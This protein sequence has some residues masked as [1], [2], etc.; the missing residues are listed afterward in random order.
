MQKKSTQ[1]SVVGGWRRSGDPMERSCDVKGI[2]GKI[3]H[4]PL[5]MRRSC[6]H[7]VAN[8]YP[9][10][11][12]HYW[13]GLENIILRCCDSHYGLIPVSFN[14]LF[15]PQPK[16]RVVG[17]GGAAQFQIIPHTKLINFLKGPQMWKGMKIASC[18]CL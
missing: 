7:P 16:K 18:S 4:K 14:L 17:E 1:E 12:T 9:P 11:H 10:G 6:T 15:P 13:W 5:C 3:F 2:T 8:R